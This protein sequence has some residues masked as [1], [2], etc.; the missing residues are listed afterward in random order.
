MIRRILTTLFVLGAA[1]NIHAGD[2]S[3]VTY[4]RNDK[5]G[6]LS[7]LVDGKTAIVYQ[8][9]SD[10]D[11]PHYYPV[12]SPSGKK[13]TVQKT[14]P[15]PHHRSFWLADKVQLAGERPVTFYAG[16]YAG[17]N[18][19]KNPAPPYKDH[20]RHVEFTHEPKSGDKPTVRS[21]LIWEMDNDKPVLDEDRVMEITPLGGGEYFLDITF[22]LTAAYGDV[23][24]FTG[25]PARRAARPAN[26]LFQY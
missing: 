2:K 23:K 7:V 6:T 18:G 5:K 10:L 20:I 11:M 4:D 8:Y 1:L 25:T 16:L 3:R 14:E 13:M 26:T 22:T 21:K 9:G 19:R 17:K 24:L 15:Y 12:L